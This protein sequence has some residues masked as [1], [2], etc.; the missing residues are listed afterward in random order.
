MWRNAALVTRAIRKFPNFQRP[1]MATP[2]DE[3]TLLR[4]SVLPEEFEWR[5]NP[6][7]I[8]L[9]EKLLDAHGARDEP[10]GGAEAHFSIRLSEAL[11]AWINVSLQT[12]AAQRQVPK[13]TVTATRADAPIVE[14]R[15]CAE[16]WLDTVDKGAYARAL[17]QPLTLRS[18]ALCV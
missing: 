8:A 10:E 17:V 11:G 6:S 3:L 1:C 4:A 16:Q 14:L 9:W 13:F 15:G 5:G 2:L 12:A 18:G 7:E